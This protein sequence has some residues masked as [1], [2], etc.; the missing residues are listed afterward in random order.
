MR[1]WLHS[2]V[3]TT[4]IGHSTAI[5]VISHLVLIGAAVYGTGVRSREIDAAVARRIFYLAP[6]DR[7]PTSDAQIEQ[8]QYVDLGTPAP[9][10]GTEPF[11]GRVPAPAGEQ[12]VP[13]N[14]GDAGTEKSSQEASVALESPDSVYSI[15]DVDE[16]AART[17]GSAAPVY[18]PELIKDGTEGGVFIRFVVDTTGR[19]DPESIEVIRAS[20]PLL[21]QSVR[22]AIPLMAFTPAMV[23]G[24]RV[25]QAV[26][27]NFEFRLQGAVPK[28]NARAKPAP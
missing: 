13:R 19:A 14:G 23:R 26:E 2:S 4:G 10:A 9:T 22:S 8:L 21:A 12:P 25:R 24:H 1:F 5:S 18:P 7:H 28:E 17:A 27:Q 6:P 20:H 16:T 11:N 3:K 15:L